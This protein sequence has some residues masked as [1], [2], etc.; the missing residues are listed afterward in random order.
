[1]KFTTPGSALP[2]EVGS[3]S[4]LLNPL[5]LLLKLVL[6]L[7]AASPGCTCGTAGPDVAPKRGPVAVE[8]SAFSVTV[9]LSASLPIKALPATAE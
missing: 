2:R 8:P 1:M 7:A 3:D 9:W 4:R 5:V 6:R